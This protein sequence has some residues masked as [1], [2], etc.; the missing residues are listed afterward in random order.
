MKIITVVALLMI[1]FG[2]AE[3]VTGFTHDFFGVSTSTGIEALYASVIIGALYSLSG[4]LILTMKKKSASLAIVCLA[5]V[6]VGRILM[7]L[8]GLY[9]LN[10]FLQVAAIVIGTAIAVMFAIYIW[11]KMDVFTS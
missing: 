8:S 3:I 10:S 1:L 4:L 7:V 11:I 2:I 5:A 6:V 9:P